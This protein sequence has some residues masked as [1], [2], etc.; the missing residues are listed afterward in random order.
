MHDKLK[1]NNIR[2]R[3]IR[4]DRGKSSPTTASVFLRLIS[5][6]HITHFLGKG[7]GQQIAIFDKQAG[8]IK[9]L[10]TIITYLWLKN[11]DYSCIVKKLRKFHICS[12]SQKNLTFSANISDIHLVRLLNK[13]CCMRAGNTC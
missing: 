7:K 9:E 10:T 5:R 8:G 11:F 3:K 6:T 4:N 2:T 13:N 12:Y 1:K